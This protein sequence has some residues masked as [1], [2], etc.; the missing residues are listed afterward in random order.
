MENKEL[1]KL[2]AGLG[3]AGLIAGAGL[4]LGAGT[5]GAAGS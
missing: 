1:K 3:I 2:L 5:G 4:T